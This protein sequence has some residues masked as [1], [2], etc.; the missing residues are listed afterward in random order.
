MWFHII[1]AFHLVFYYHNAKAA[2]THVCHII[3][4]TQIFHVQNWIFLSIPIVLYF[5]SQ[6]LVFWNFNIST[7][8][9]NS[10][11]ASKVLWHI[12][13]WKSIS[14]SAQYVTPD[15]KIYC[16]RVKMCQFSSGNFFFR[17]KFV[18]LLCT[19]KKDYN[20]S[21]LIVAQYFWL[22]DHNDWSRL[23]TVLSVGLPKTKI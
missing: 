20:K 13:R 23:S 10:V 22:V 8:S 5:P 14:T 18:Q 12:H 6:I 11:E 21:D 2:S 17:I 9:L 4:S 15:S 3:N 19:S 7:N 16:D 1:S